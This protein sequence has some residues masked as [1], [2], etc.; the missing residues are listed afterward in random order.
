M[1]DTTAPEIPALT[2]E[3]RAEITRELLKII[4]FVS[5]TPPPRE[6]LLKAIEGALDSGQYRVS[7][8]LPRPDALRFVYDRM[9]PDV[10]RRAID[11]GAPAES[12]APEGRDGTTSKIPDGGVFRS[13]AGEDPR[14][15]PGFTSFRRKV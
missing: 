4:E 6:L 5:T 7:E 12:D 9:M 3:D 2:P 14:P 13:D 15:G 8:K 1:A 10:V 11:L